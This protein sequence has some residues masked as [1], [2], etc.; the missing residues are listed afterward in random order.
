MKTRIKNKKNPNYNQKLFINV[1]QSADIEKPSQDKDKKH[2]DNLGK[3]QQ[4]H[5]PYSVGK[6]RMDQDKG[7]IYK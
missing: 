6:I 7:I 3:G 5:I 4:W 1:C 2:N